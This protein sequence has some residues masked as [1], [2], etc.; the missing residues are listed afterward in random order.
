MEQEAGYA[1]TIR[2]W[3]NSEEPEPR[4]NPMTPPTTKLEK[5]V[6]DSTNSAAVAQL[7]SPTSAMIETTPVTAFGFI[8]K[9]LCVPASLPAFAKGFV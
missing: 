5:E 7:K 9:R 3:S 4:W 2:M 6:K 1:V 8:S